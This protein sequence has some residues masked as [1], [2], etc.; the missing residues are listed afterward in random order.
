MVF[1]VW[2]GS[3][4]ADSAPPYARSKD[5]NELRR[6]I[7]AKIR[8]HGVPQFTLEIVPMSAAIQNGKIVG[9]CGGNTK[10]IV[11]S[12]QPMPNMN[13]LDAGRQ[14]SAD[15]SEFDACKIARSK[16]DLAFAVDPFYHNHY[17]KVRAAFHTCIA[18]NVVC[19]WGYDAS[20]ADRIWSGRWGGDRELPT[21]HYV[22]P[23]DASSATS[24]PRASAAVR[25]LGY[26]HTTGHDTCILFMNSGGS[27]G[28]WAWAG[29]EILDDG[30]VAKLDISPIEDDGAFQLNIAQQSPHS[31][32]AII[33][34]EFQKHFGDEGKMTSHKYLGSE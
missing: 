29:W 15:A 32:G 8:Q 1:L 9:T 16:I 34:N 19:V 28:Y 31:V 33:W 6:E 17:L 21:N 25:A 23:E 27:G 10:K 20:N 4:A 26:S 2:L 13:P 12:K 18:S 3:Y 7:E 14:E 5:C 22:K 11:Y 30:S 24:Y